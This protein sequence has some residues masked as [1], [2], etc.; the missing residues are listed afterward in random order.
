[1]R[2][3]TSGLSCELTL[4]I[5]VNLLNKDIDIFRLVVYIQQVEEQNKKQAEMSKRQSKKFH[6][7]N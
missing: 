7:L 2:K 5:K 3:F 4:E 6:Y 1:M